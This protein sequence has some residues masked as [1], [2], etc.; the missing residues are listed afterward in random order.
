MWTSDIES[1]VF[2]RVKAKGN[3]ALKSKYPNIYF[4]TNDKVQKQPQFPTVYLHEVGSVEQGM[5]L[6]NTEI[7]A[8]LNTIQVDVTDNES[9][10]RAKEVMS[11]IVKTMKSMGYTVISLPQFQN[12]DNVYRQT[13]RFR[14]MIGKGDLF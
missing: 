6:E 1:M 13:A 10:G 8:V 7:N 4:T 14:R 2:T 5:D 12:T 9:Q 3:N 11:N